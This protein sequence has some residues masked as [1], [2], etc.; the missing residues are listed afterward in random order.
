MRD[1]AAEQQFLAVRTV[2]DMAGLFLSMM[3]ASP[4]AGKAVIISSTLRWAL[5]NGTL[6]LFVGVAGAVRSC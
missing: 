2:T 5:I 1:L 6:L 3:N 4:S